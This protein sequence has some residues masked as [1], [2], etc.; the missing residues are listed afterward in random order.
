MA[1][2]LPVFPDHATPFSKEQELR[3][4]REAI[5]A[6]AA[7]MF[8][9]EGVSAARVEDISARL[10]L[11]KNSVSYY[12]ET[13]DEIIAAAYESTAAFLAEALNEAE[14]PTL[15]ALFERYAQQWIAV[16]ERRRAYVCAPDELDLLPQSLR[17]RVAE[18]FAPSI[19]RVQALVERWAIARGA[20]LGRAETAAAGVLALLESLGPMIARSGGDAGDAWRTLRSILNRGLGGGAQPPLLLGESA[21]VAAIARGA[22]DREARN[23]LK[24]EAFLTMG[25]RMFNER[26]YGGVGLGEIAEALGVS[27]GAFYYHF[28]DKEALLSAYFERCWRD[29]EA[30]FIAAEE[31][32]LWGPP[33]VRSALQTALVQRLSGGAQ[34]P[35]ESLWPALPEGE[36]SR[37]RRIEARVRRRIAAGIEA[38]EGG[39][40]VELAAALVLAV[41]RPESGCARAGALVYPGWR[42]RGEPRTEAFDYLSP[43]FLGI[44]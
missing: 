16:A 40:D 28:P 8:D 19:A 21:S 5:L 20:A 37:L 9:S 4:K 26:G 38:C 3:L 10:G 23:A 29:L 31:E 22:F 6:A 14:A 27:R 44:S 7:E 33:A 1:V 15:A 18:A 30:V 12:F 13:K 34:L 24:R 42:V 41:L 39:V 35:R 2:I 17:L 25:G 36:R 32:G 11:S 43:L